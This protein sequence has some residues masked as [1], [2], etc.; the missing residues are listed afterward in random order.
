MESFVGEFTCGVGD[1]A[2]ALEGAT[3][4]VKLRLTN[5]ENE[6]EYYDVNVV[7]HTF[8]GN[9]VI[10]GTTVVTTADGLQDAF[11]NGSGNI[12]LGGDIDL[13]DLFG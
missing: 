1:V 8:G 3:F 2:D 13:N 10:D 6:A 7:T 5:P 9:S 12:E 4:T 11:E